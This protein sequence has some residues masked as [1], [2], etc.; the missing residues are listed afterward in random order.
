MALLKHLTHALL[1]GSIVGAVAVESSSDSSV[2]AAAPVLGCKS[3]CSLAAALETS[4]D[5]KTACATTCY[6]AVAKRNDCKFKRLVDYACL[7]N[8]ADNK[9]SH[10]TNAVMER[11]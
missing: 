10:G 4:T 3:I 5:S 7:C 11:N 2:N 8:I 6:D 9:V 1:A